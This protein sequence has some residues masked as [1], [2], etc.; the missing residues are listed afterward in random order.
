MPCRKEQKKVAPSS[1]RLELKIQAQRAKAVIARLTLEFPG[2]LHER[3]RYIEML[4]AQDPPG[5]EISHQRLLRH[6]MAGMPEIAIQKGIAR[7]RAMP[8]TVTGV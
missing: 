2:P 7:H 5:F 3:Q 8:F 4:K 1:L 6:M